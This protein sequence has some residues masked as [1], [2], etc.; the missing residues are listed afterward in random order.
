MT[1][2]NE[3]MY[4]FRQPELTPM[5]IH[6]CSPKT[7]TDI[8][9]QQSPPFKPHTYPE[10]YT[11]TLAPMESKAKPAHTFLEDGAKTLKARA[12]LRDTPEGERTAGKIAEVFNAITGHNIT[13]ADA[14]MFLIVLKIVRSR[15]GKYNEDDY[16]DLSAYSALLG[17][18]ESTR[19]S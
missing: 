12:E 19:K 5:G 4:D 3:Q 2:H 15:A 1:T 8:L 16:I 10:P 11:L 13:E 18:H 14:W 17:E 6:G 9:G 7:H